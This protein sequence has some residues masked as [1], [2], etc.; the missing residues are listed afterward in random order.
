MTGRDRVNLVCKVI[1]KI[2]HYFLRALYYQPK[3]GEPPGV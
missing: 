3:V 2:N 1:E